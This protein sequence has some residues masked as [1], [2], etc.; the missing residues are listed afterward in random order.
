MIIKKKIGTSV[1]DQKRRFAVVVVVST[2]FFDALK[3][4]QHDPG[5]MEIESL[6]TNFDEL[7]AE[8]SHQEIENLQIFSRISARALVV[9]S[10]MP[11]CHFEDA[12]FS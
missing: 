10:D 2:H 11:H 1:E 7:N 3:I 12:H 6:L 9:T 5:R 4:D 8:L